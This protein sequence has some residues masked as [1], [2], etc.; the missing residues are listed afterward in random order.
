MRDPL[1][2]QIARIAGRQHGN[3]TTWQLRALG[4]S[5][6]VISL[7]DRSGRLFRVF[8][9]VYAVG[10]PPTRPI[11]RISAAVLA[12]GKDAAASHE[13]AAFL[14]GL[15]KEFRA[16]VD[17]VAPGGHRR[18]GIRSHRSTRLARQDLRRHQGIPLTSP[19][20]TLLD[21]A[22]HLNRRELRRAVSQARIS[23]HLKLE[24]LA[25]V[26]ARFP[27]H[28]GARRLRQDV[29]DSDA[30]PTR[31]EFEEAFLEL[32]REFGLPRPTLNTRVAGYEVDA[33]FAEERVVVELDGWQYHRDRG[34]WEQ[35][36]RKDAD[37]V[38][39]RFVPV[40]ITWERMSEGPATEAARLRR[41]I[42]AQRRAA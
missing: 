30:G 36:R 16:P 4:L 22:P 6:Q 40:H 34:I 29:L 10:R 20:R 8:E 3:I 11:E 25:D 28:P 24:A 23:G 13:S 41:I 7:R 14:W 9:G 37:L 17:V 19:A 5:D 12:C 31:S 2:A 39:A 35:D 38:A 32:T 21:V 26:V 27:R 33:L 1:D 42:D 18:P 15:R